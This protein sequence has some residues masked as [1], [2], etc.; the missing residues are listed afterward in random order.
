VLDSLPPVAE[1]IGGI[2]ADAD[3]Q[4]RRLTSSN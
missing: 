3:A 2:M 4:L 1:I